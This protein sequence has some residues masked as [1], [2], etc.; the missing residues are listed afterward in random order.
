VA[1]HVPSL[2]L[3][4]VDTVELRPYERPARRRDLAVELDF[5]AREAGEP[6][7]WVELKTGQR[8][9]DELATFQL[10]GSDCDDI[11]NVVRQTNL[12]AYVFHVQ[13]ER[14]YSPPSDRVVGRAIWWTDIYAMTD[15]FVRMERR[16]RN[17]GKMAAHF[18]RAC[19][20]PLELLGPA[21]RDGHH[22]NLWERLRQD[23]P[24]AMYRA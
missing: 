1:P 10:D 13:L 8:S 22:R 12:P 11:L 20:Q 16:R 24:P 21:L 23:G 4:V 17:G 14:E 9:I 18:A 19:F 15:A 2:V 6:K 7:F 5:R 3:E